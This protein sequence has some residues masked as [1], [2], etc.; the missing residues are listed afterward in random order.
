MKVAGESV[1]TFA[2]N[3]MVSGKAFSRI[4]L[5]RKKNVARKLKS[6]FKSQ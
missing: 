4:K 3:I 5:N 6:T 1:R 2:S